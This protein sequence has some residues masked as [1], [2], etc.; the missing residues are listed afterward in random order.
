MPLSAKEQL[1]KEQEKKDIQA[2]L[3]GLSKLASECLD[4]EKFKHYRDEFERQMY[5]VFEKLEAGIDPDPIKDAH[6]LRACINTILI[7][8]KLINCPQKDIKKG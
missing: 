6:Y 4:D 2:R 5:D 8:K 3:E 7:L 1:Q